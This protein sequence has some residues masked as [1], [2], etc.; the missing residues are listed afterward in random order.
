MWG[1]TTAARQYVFMVSGL[2]LALGALSALGG[3]GAAA[4]ADAP[5]QEMDGDGTPDD[6]YIVTSATELQA[7]ETDLTAHYVLGNDIDASETSEWNDGLGFLPIGDRSDRFEGHLDGRNHTI[8]DLTVDRPLRGNVGLFGV[9]HEQGVVENLGL[10]GVDL[11]GYGPVGGVAGVSSGTIDSVMVSGEIRATDEEAAGIVGQFTDEPE[12]YRT[13]SDTS[14]S[15]DIVGGIVADGTIDG[16][17]HASA[18]HGTVDGET[19]AGGIVGNTAYVVENAYSTA[20]VEAPL[21]RGALIGQSLPRGSITGLYWNE[22]DSAVSDSIGYEQGT[23]ADT[24]ELQRSQMTGPAASQHMPSLFTDANFIQTDSYPVLKRHIVGLS[25]AVEDSPVAVDDTMNATVRLELLDGSTVTASGTDV[26]GFDASVLSIDRGVIEPSETGETEVTA[27]VGEYSDTTTLDVRT[28]ADISVRAALLP[29]ET[30]LANT[31]APLSVEVVNTGDLSGTETIPVR[32]GAETAGEATVSLQSDTGESVSIP[33]DVPSPGEYAVTV[34]DTQAGTLRVVSN[35]SVTVE[36]F[37]TPAVVPTVG[38]YNATAVFANENDVAVTVPVS[39]AAGGDQRREFLTVEPGTNRIE[40]ERPSTG[41][42]GETLDHA[43]RFQRTERTATSEVQALPE[44]TIGALDGPETVEPGETVTLSVTVENT[45]PGDG[46][47]MAT[48][49]FDG[50]NVTTVQAA[51]RGGE[52]TE[53]TAEVT[54]DE[55]GTVEYSAIVADETVT[56]SLTVQGDDETPGNDDDDDDDDGDGQTP[57]DTPTV[58]TDGTGT[59]S[60][61][62]DDGDGFGVLAGLLAVA[63]AGLLAARRS[64]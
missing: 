49:R 51:A 57:T 14:V 4:T 33:V 18:A 21:L 55:P 11:R 23:G 37:E 40:F 8:Y 3:A 24:R 58:T 7:I 45:G 10:A 29:G 60:T 27:T 35:D 5:L 43:L 39:I 41:A 64:S 62:D 63:L 6:P 52:S 22:M 16:V 32:I 20:G 25:V 56:R 1:T 26:Y 53:I 12:I 48:L 31:S 9:I 34:G 42:A 19:Q 61:D 47:T 46:R 38:G 28:P 59:D 13:V 44:W 15:G 50:R 36:R 17:V 2:L 54:P 30:L